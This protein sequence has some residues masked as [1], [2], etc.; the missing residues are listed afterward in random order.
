VGGVDEEN[1]KVVGIPNDAKPPLEES[2]NEIDPV[3]G[4]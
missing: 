4:L 1:L 2:V 3:E